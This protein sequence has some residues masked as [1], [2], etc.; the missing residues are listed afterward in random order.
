MDSSLSHRAAG[1]VR[2]VAARKG[3]VIVVNKWDLAEDRS[4]RHGFA[5]QVD[6]RYQFVGTAAAEARIEASLDNRQQHLVAAARR[7]LAA[8]GPADCAVTLAL[9][10]ACASPM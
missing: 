5:R 3:L 8:L 10:K 6:H 7:L 9:A 4:D 1:V 2:Q